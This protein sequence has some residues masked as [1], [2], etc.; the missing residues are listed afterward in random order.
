MQLLYVSQKLQLKKTN[1]NTG[2]KLGNYISVYDIECAAA[3]KATV[4]IYYKNRVSKLSLNAA[5]LFK[6]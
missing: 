5:E 1:A 2:V 3:D 6:R 4:Q